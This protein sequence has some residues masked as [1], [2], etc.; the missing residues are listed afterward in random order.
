MEK[1][2][3]EVQGKLRTV[4]F[5]DAFAKKMVVS[6]LSLRGS[7]NFRDFSDAQQSYQ[8]LLA[9][10]TGSTV[11]GQIRDELKQMQPYVT[12]SAKFDLPRFKELMRAAGAKLGNG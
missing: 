12:K 9:L 7:N 8:A 11:R 10:T 5:D 4:K 6:I 2:I 3:D 1:V